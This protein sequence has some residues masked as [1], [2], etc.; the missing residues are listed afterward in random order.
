M[1]TTSTIFPF[2]LNPGFYRWGYA[3]PGHQIVSILF[4]IWSRGCNNQLARALPVL[5]TWEIFAGAAAVFDSLHRNRGARQAIWA[6]AFKGS[7]EFTAPLRRNGTSCNAA[8]SSRGS[9]AG[10][11]AANGDINLP[12]YQQGQ[13]SER[14]ELHSRPSYTRTPQF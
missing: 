1:K 4:Q 5:F 6:D 9:G 10:A 2:E 7:S 3:L 13:C 8:L 12:I 14:Y 11:K